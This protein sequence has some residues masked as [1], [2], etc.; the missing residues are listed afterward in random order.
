MSNELLAVA[1]AII[2]LAEQADS[3]LLKHI[4]AE[5]AALILY[6]V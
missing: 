6:V 5:S 1:G 4:V 3:S 2:L